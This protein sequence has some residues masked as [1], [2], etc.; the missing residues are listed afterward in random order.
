MLPPGRRGRSDAHRRQLPHPRRRR[1]RASATRSRSPPPSRPAAKLAYSRVQGLRGRG[2]AAHPAGA[3]LPAP[4]GVRG[5]PQG[6]AGGAAGSERDGG[7]QR[8]ASSCSPASPAGWSRRAAAAAPSCAAASSARG[9]PTLRRGRP[10][11]RSSLRTRPSPPTW[12]GC[13]ATWSSTRAC[14]YRRGSYVVYLKGTGRGGRSAGAGR[15]ARGRPAGGGAVGGEGGALAR[16]PAGQLRLGQPAAHER[17]RLAAAGGHRR[18][19][20]SR[21]GW[22]R[23]PPAL[24]EMADLRLQYP[25]LNLSEL[26]EAGGEGLTRSAVNHRLRRLVEAAERTGAQRGLC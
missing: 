20:A 14:G 5:A 22:R 4:A 1:P 8:H 12:S 16:Q 23:F 9:R 10:I 17:R 21:A 13:S 2:G 18:P 19:G 15:G 3:A 6:D 24:R 11:W 7:A 26:A 25:Y